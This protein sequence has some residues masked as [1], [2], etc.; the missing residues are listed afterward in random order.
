MPGSGPQ[1]RE[2]LSASEIEAFRSTYASA[3]A[4]QIE[5]WNTHDAEVI[6]QVY[7][8][9]AVHLDGSVQ[10]AGIDQIA[11]MAA[12]M[13]T[14]FPG[15][16][17]RLAGVYTGRND[18]L[19]RWEIFGILTWTSDNPIVEYDLLEI[20]EGKIASWRL[21]YDPDT[22]PFFTSSTERDEATASLLHSYASAWSSSDPAAVAALY[23]VDAVREDSLFEERIESRNGIESYAAGWFCWYPSATLELVDIITERTVADPV[24]GG[25]FALQ[26]SEEDAGEVRLAVLLNTSGKN[27]IRERLYYDVESLVACGW[28]S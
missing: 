2:P 23:A 27:I 25:V 6:Q 20:R 26:M 16:E 9:D 19:D 21:L 7:T 4:S 8:Q 12:E 11:A 3:A 1:R 22:R 13:D 24:I 5:A 17:G 14:M 15:M 28:A 18:G 10:L